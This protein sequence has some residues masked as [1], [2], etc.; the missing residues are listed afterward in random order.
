LAVAALAAQVETAADALRQA[1][2]AAIDAH[3]RRVLAT[4]GA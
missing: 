2:L 3:V 4:G 1:R